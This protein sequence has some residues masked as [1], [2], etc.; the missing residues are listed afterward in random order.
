M[1]DDTTDDIVERLRG[2]QMVRQ[3][4][5]QFGNLN[6]FGVAADEIER[7]RAENDSLRSVIDRPDYHIVRFTEDGWTVQHPPQDGASLFDCPYVGRFGETPQEG[8]GDYRWDEDGL[9]KLEGTLDE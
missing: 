1:S 6:I 8:L 7:L 5:G 4:A 2:A 3:A 9:T